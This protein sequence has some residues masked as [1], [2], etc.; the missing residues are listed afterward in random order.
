M[1]FELNEYLSKLLTNQNFHIGL[2]PDLYH[3]NAKQKH[4]RQQLTTYALYDCLSMERIIIQMKNKRFEFNSHS[5]KY[6]QHD[7]L[8]LFPTSSIDDNIYLSTQSTPFLSNR[9]VTIVKSST[10]K[11]NTVLSNQTSILQVE[12]RTPSIEFLQNNTPNLRSLHIRTENYTPEQFSLSKYVL[13]NITVEIII[14]IFK[15]C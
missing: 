6:I 2:D 4:Y 7:S 3:L 13:K 14:K 9:S 15:V 11:Q 10:L 5:N 8:E 1:A 12:P